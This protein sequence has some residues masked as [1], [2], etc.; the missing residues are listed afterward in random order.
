MAAHGRAR[1]LRSRAPLGEGDGRAVRRRRRVGH[2]ALVRARTALA[3]LHALR[4]SAHRHALLARGFRLLPRGDLPRRLSVRVGARRPARASR[5]R[6]RRGGER[7]GVGRVRRARQR[8]DEHTGRVH[9]RRG[10]RASRAIDPVAAMRSPAAFQ[11]ALHMLLA[12][13]AATG[14]AVAGVHA[15]DA[16]ARRGARRSTAAR[17]RWR[18]ASARR[19]RCCSRSRAT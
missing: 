19:R 2:G 14:M 8:L 10:G 1:V 6:R 17:S 5:G 4:R 15:L 13:Y 18:S 12:S 7:R 3:G 11:Q 9:A 16:A